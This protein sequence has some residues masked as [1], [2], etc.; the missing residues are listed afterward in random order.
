[1]ARLLPTR[2]L[3]A[4][5]REPAR[6]SAF[7][8]EP[9]R[10]AG[11]FDTRYLTRSSAD[12]LFGGRMWKM[13][14]TAAKS[15]RTNAVVIAARRRFS[16]LLRIVSHGSAGRDALRVRTPALCYHRAPFFVRRSSNF[17]H[18]CEYR[19]MAVAPRRTAYARPSVAMLQSRGRRSGRYLR[20]NHQPIERTRRARPC[21]MEKTVESPRL[22]VRLARQKTPASFSEQP[23]VGP[24]IARRGGKL[25]DCAPGVPFWI[26][27]KSE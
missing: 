24:E 13:S 5:R 22:W 27:T 23:E 2:R 14:L 1:M 18:A 11:S 12:R 20:P 6:D 10:G 16:M 19:P 26:V 17:L 4:E 3:G 7:Q 15:R 9:R 21:M 8:A 25:A